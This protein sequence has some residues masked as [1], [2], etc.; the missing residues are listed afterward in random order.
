MKT[1]ISMTIDSKVFDDFRILC[2]KNGYKL[3]TRVEH[4][5]R[6]DVLNKTADVFY[7]LHKLETAIIDMGQDIQQL[8]K[9]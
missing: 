8:K 6:Q 9:K 5:I 2:E 7:H 3:S 1:K 4:L